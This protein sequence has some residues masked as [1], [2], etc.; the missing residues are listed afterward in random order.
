[1]KGRRVP[2]SATFRAILSHIGTPVS[3]NLAKSCHNA[4]SKP[5]KH[6]RNNFV[7]LMLR[8]CCAHVTLMLRSC[9]AHVTLT[10]LTCPSL[11]PHLPLTCPNATKICDLNVFLNKNMQS[12]TIIGHKKKKKIENPLVKWNGREWKHSAK[13]HQFWRSVKSIQLRDVPS[14]AVVHDFH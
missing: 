8:S 10:P 13:K 3:V 6:L 12:Q 5:L 11:A 4:A 14:R 9:Y 2:K 1:M 7:T